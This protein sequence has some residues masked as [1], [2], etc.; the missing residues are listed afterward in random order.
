MKLLQILNLIETELGAV[1]LQE[2]FMSNYKFFLYIKNK[3]LI[4]CAIVRDV[5]EGYKIEIEKDIKEFSTIE[6][7][8]KKYLFYFIS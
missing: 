8:N 4:G 3:K 6:K 2:K 5:S 7:I 1:Q